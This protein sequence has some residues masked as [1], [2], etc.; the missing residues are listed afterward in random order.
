M[1]TAYIFCGKRKL[2]AAAAQ[3]VITWNM[4]SAGQGEILK[5]VGV[6]KLGVH[7]ITGYLKENSDQ[8][9]HA[10]LKVSS[11]YRRCQQY[12]RHDSKRK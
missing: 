5:N 8:I 6:K 10:K 3:A 4:G 12:L 2:E 7:T 11:T 1:P 9:Y